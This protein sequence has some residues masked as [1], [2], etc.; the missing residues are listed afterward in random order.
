MGPGNMNKVLSCDGHW[1][2]NRDMINAGDKHY[3]EH[4]LSRLDN[5]TII[6]IRLSDGSYC[7]TKLINTALEKQYTRT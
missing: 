1:I 6:R 5:G 4:V 7:E 2:D 3:F